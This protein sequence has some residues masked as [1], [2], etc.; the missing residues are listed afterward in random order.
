MIGGQCPPYIN[1]NEAG[2][3]LAAE[4]IFNYLEDHKLIKVD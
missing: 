3:R 4:L 1:W 2:N